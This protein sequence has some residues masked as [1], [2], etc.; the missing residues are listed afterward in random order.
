MTR[1]ETNTAWLLAC[2][3]IAILSA[4]IGWAARVNTTADRLTQAQIQRAESM[5]LYFD[6]QLDQIIR[7]NERRYR[8]HGTKK[9]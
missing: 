9:N 3:S 7:D 4:T 5:K 6:T 1:Q 8:Q 2:L